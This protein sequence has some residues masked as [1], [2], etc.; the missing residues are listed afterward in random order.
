MKASGKISV[1]LSGEAAR[2]LRRLV[3]DEGFASAGA[4]MEE[5]FR[6]WLQSRSRWT[7]RKRWTAAHV[8]RSFAPALHAPLGEPYERVELLFD[9][10]DAKA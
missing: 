10:G 9:A 7:G 4:V 5:A 1:T 2:E 6:F 8:T 3:E